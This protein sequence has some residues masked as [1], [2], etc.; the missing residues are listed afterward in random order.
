MA[1]TK[2]IKGLVE[3]WTNY[4]GLL[5]GIINP[6]SAAISWNAPEL[7]TTGF[8][9]DP[10]PD[11][12]PSTYLTG[13]QEWTASIE[14]TFPNTAK[15]GSGG[16]VTFASGYAAN[17]HAFEVFM[18]FA[19]LEDTSFTS[20][21]ITAK[22]FCS[23]KGSWGGSYE[24]KVD[25][26]TAVSAPG[27]TGSATF[28]LTEDGATDNSLAGTI[29]IT[30]V[31]PR[32][33]VGELNTVAHTFRGSGNLTATGSALRTASNGVF[34]ATDGIWQQPVVTGSTLTMV[35]AG[36]RDYS[37]LAFPRRVVWRVTPGEVNRIAIEAQG[38][39]ALTPG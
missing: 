22:T 6:A 34:D 29:F 11:A 33:A 26:T 8:A 31:G 37:G 27:T 2:G 16:F 36:D 15:T 17:V 39:G 21:G 1:S 35:A 23:G 28:K 13:L 12:F 10:D 38:S 7:E 18:E 19:A 3:S 9:S 24:A 5:S 4:A 25:D 30:S 14:G 32:I 20:S